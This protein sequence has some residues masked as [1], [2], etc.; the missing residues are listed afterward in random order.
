MADEQ[1][2]APDWVPDWAPDPESIGYVQKALATSFLIAAG[3]YITYHVLFGSNRTAVKTAVGK[4][5]G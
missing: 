2:N 4:G 5:A 3:A 1:S